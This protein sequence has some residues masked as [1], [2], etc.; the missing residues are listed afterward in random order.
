MTVR[1]EL[2]PECLANY[3]ALVHDPSCGYMLNVMPLCSLKWGDEHPDQFGDIHRDPVP[4]RTCNES[5]IRLAGART[6]LWRNGV[7]PE[8][9]Q[10][11]WADAQR[12]IPDWPGF[13]RKSLTPEELRSLDGCAE[14][15]EDVLGTMAEH[16]SEMTLTYKEGGLTELSAK[17]A[18]DDI[19]TGRASKPW[20][21]FW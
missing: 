6:H 13:K 15:L 19:E 8:D 21:R 17:R 20:W 3:R 18:S 5:I 7:I 1:F 10:E 2:C 12:L 16:F 9:C 4:H 11:L 14:E